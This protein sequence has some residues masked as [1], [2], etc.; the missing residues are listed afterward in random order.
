MSFIPFKEDIQQVI[1]KGFE[2]F[3]SDKKENM[4]EILELGKVI[5]FNLM[6]LIEFGTSRV[7]SIKKSEKNSFCWVFNDIDWI[8]FEQSLQ[9]VLEENYF[10]FLNKSGPCIFKFKA[11]TNNFNYEI[12]FSRLVQINIE[13]KKMRNIMRF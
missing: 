11:D 1:E 12:D 2:K 9:N 7:K 5:D 8:P 3:L 10:E 4:V 13:T 6:K